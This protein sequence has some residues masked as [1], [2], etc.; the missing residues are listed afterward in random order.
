MSKS[1]LKM[2]DTDTRNHNFS[3]DNGFDAKMC[4]MAA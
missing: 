1:M 4:E 3:I 2:L